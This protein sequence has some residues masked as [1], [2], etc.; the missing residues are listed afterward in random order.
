MNY[1]LR[2]TFKVFYKKYLYYR[3]ERWNSKNVEYFKSFT[4]IIF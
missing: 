2:L 1:P 3:W 4:R